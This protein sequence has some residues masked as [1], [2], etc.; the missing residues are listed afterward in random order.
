MDI[1][2]GVNSKSISIHS[3]A[4]SPGYF[5]TIGQ[6]LLEGRDF[7]DADDGR[8]H[9]VI[10]NKGLA[11]REWPS[12]TALGHRIRTGQI[13]APN[14]QGWGTVV[15]VV[16]NVNNYDLITEPGPDLYIPRAEDPSR[17]AR[18]VVNGKGDPAS[19]KNTVRNAFKSRFPEASAYGFETM[20]E[21]MSF[22]VA[23]R[24]FLMQVSDCVRRGRS[25]PFHSWNL[26]HACI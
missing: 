10:V 19:L 2:N 11:E 13:H 6:V 3:Y 12:E 5:S 4:I 25:I 23:E 20:A 9:V 7:N 18:F 22:E 24:E 15:G 21:E 14:D 16:G 17:F 1:Q 8:N 26:R